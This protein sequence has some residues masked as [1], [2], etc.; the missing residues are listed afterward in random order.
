MTGVRELNYT[1]VPSASEQVRVSVL[2]GRTQ[3]DV[4]LPLDVEMASLLP[5]LVKLVRSRDAEAPEDSAV[6][7]APRNFWVLSRLDTGNALQPDQTLRAAGVA[8]GALLVLTARQAL[9]PPTLYDDVVDAAARLNKAAYAGWDA[10][11]A[12]WM[13][14]AGVYLASL[15]WVYFLVD[16]A[17]RP[18][19]AAFLGVAVVVV[20]A[21]VG[22]AALAY[23][24]YGLADHGAAIGWATIPINA[25]IVW[26]SV[27]RFG[28][29]GVAGGCAVLLVV[30]AV[31]Y[32]AIGT[33][34]WGYVASGAFF[35]GGGLAMISHA[36]GVPVI[37]MGVGLA[38]AGAL[39]CLT[40]GR[41]TVRLRRPQ[42]P[43]VEADID[44]DGPMFKNPFAPRTATETATETQS[45]A[46]MPTAEQVWARVRSATL[47][48]SALF[49]GLAASVVCGA[50]TAL[51]A[52]PPVQWSE[53][54]FALVCA[55]LLGLR[56]RLPSTVLE[57]VSLGVPALGLAVIACASA[58]QGLFSIHWAG[59]V[60]L[61]VI[62]VA[63]V[64]AG[65]GVA[66]VR[67]ERRL[68]T[69]ANYLEYAAFTALIPV[70]LWADGTLVRLGIW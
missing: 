44:R 45:A 54:C 62:A 53:W 4:V 9:S 23:R 17:F 21:L 70:A 22:V 3:L 46:A 48:R 31:C 64:A 40:V 34:H 35:A 33:G 47:T 14:F 68:A 58:Q 25:A 66:G 12:R 61:L 42:P 5:E 59:F 50:T 8:N 39:G 60:T 65:L 10:F 24:V 69:A 19:R 30:N 26:A 49:V 1:R 2:G 16:G 13:A 7:Q 29:Y 6:H 57:R 38:V 56:A 37:T 18:Q 67:L 55:I 51:R 63:A 27:Q 20:A 15:V 32:R 52:S 28:D 41:M 36:L 43:T 11:A